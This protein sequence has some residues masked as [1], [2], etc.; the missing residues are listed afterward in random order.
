MLVLLSLVA[1]AAPTATL[2]VSADGCG[3]WTAHAETG[4]LPGAMEADG[5]QVRS[6]GRDAGIVTAKGTAVP[7]G[8]VVL[9][10]R[11][12]KRVLTQERLTLPSRTLFLVPVV[13][14]LPLNQQGGRIVVEWESPCDAVPVSWS[15][16]DGRGHR[17]TKDRPNI[18]LYVTDDEVGVYET[19]I[20]LLLDTG[21]EVQRTVHY[22]VGIT[23]ED[24][25]GKTQQRAGGRD[26]DDADPSIPTEEAPDPDGI[27]QDCDGIIDEGTVAYDDDGD[28]LSELEGDCDDAASRVSP[29]LPELVDCRDNDCDGEVDEQGALPLGWTDVYEDNNTRDTPF[30]LIG[31]GVRDFTR[32]LRLMMTPGDEDWF[33][34]W[35]DDGWFDVWGINATFGSVPVAVEVEVWKGDS[36][37]LKQVVQEDGEVVRIAGSMSD[38]TGWWRIGVR[39]LS[40]QVCPVELV[41]VGR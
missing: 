1:F 6:W 18:E 25:D 38:D 5:V 16:S 7:D 28:G 22:E 41:L 4:R 8:D 30:E 2:E 15:T 17:L 37:Q 36:R 40:E 26:C 33:K 32:D 31:R 14:L 34:F 12:G 19:A 27:D 39:A 35:S 3:V 9:T 29:E 10:V 23:D 11:K 13:D 20:T 24:G 21:E